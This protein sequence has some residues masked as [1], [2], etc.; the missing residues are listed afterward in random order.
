MN[1]PVRKVIDNQFDEL[2]KE[3]SQYTDYLKEEE[4]ARIREKIRLQ[5][6][7]L[8]KEIAGINDGADISNNQP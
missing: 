2:K 7:N 4:K 1:D 5:I 6:I 3:L 8:E